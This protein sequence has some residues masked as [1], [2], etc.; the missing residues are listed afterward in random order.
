MK[1]QM[2][3]VRL[4]TAGSVA[5]LSPYDRKDLYANEPRHSRSSNRNFDC[6]AYRTHCNL[7]SIGSHKTTLAS[8]SHWVW[9]GNDDD[10][11][12]RFSHIH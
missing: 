4:K 3:R 9:L 6:V 8:Q 5:E 11:I 10:R 12:C 7:G 1:H 2:E